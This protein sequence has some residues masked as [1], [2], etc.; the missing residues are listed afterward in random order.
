VPLGFGE[1]GEGPPAGGPLP[2]AGLW[3]A[4]RV[5]SARS[6]LLADP[7]P[8]PPQQAQ[9]ARFGGREGGGPEIELLGADLDRLEPA[10][11]AHSPGAHAHG[12]LRLTLYWRALRP[13][14]VSYTVFVHALDAGGEIQ[15]QW[16]SE[17]LG[18]TYP[19]DVWP[20][21]VVVRDVYTVPVGESASPDGYRLAVG[22][23][24][25]ATMER[26]PAYDEGGEL[27][28]DGRVLLEMRN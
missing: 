17:P 3:A 13:V 7:P 10:Q 1:P 26:L 5:T 9:V 24:E 12:A 15:G 20:V 4:P 16:D 14:D 6:W 25:W 21:G 27:W 23:Y 11:G 8:E 22:L 28:P 18:G 2:V 19:T